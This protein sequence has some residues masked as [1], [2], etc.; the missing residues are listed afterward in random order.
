[1]LFILFFFYVSCICTKASPVMID[2]L[3]FVVDVE[4][5]YY[6][7]NIAWLITIFSLPTSLLDTCTLSPSYFLY[8]C[9]T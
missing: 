2:I 3:T 1:M 6:I 8:T 4:A 7:I 5:I 9:F